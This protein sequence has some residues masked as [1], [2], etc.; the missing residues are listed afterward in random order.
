MA[1]KKEQVFLSVVVQGTDKIVGMKQQMVELKK[2]ISD[3]KTQLKK[4]GANLQDLS[5]KLAQQE[6]NLKNKQLVLQQEWLLLWVLLRLQVI[7]LCVLWV[8]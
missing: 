6:V 2:A 3:T 1:Q 8:L 5:R 7:C 4:K